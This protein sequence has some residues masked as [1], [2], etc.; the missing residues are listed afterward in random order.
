MSHDMAK[1]ET[2]RFQRRFLP[3]LCS[4]FV[5]AFPAFSAYADPM[6][7]AECIGCSETVKETRAKQVAQALKPYPRP[8]DYF[9]VAVYDFNGNKVDV[10]YVGWYATG[11]EG[12][13]YRWFVQKGTTPTAIV[14]AFAA[15]RTAYQRNGNSLEFMFDEN[16][17]IP[18][19][20]GGSNYTLADGVIS[21]EP[22]CRDVPDTVRTAYDVIR[23]SAY[24]N[25][26][27]SEIKGSMTRIDWLNRFYYDS[28]P[29]MAFVGGLF[30]LDY[31]YLNTGN[32]RVFLDGSSIRFHYDYAKRDLEVTP[33]TAKLCGGYELPEEAKEIPSKI[34]RFQGERGMYRFIGYAGDLGAGS[35][36][37]GTG[38]VTYRC[39][40][41]E[42]NGRVW[43]TCTKGFN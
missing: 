12:R 34:W 36:L 35:T 20:D 6:P 25:Q 39:E 8:G 17:Y 41:G 22:D 7:S 23:D 18:P 37:I 2:P 32:H 5:A 28:L 31:R 1:V 27:V 43:I 15:A 13:P 21:S 24:K 10:Y 4:F 33:G 14:N 9:D 26:L 16:G 3:Y 29:A 11:Q 42:R 30:S 40:G 38:N 19:A